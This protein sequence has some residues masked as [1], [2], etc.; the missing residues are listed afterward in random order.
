MYNRVPANRRG[1]N[2]EFLNEVDEFVRLAKEAA[3]RDTKT[4]DRDPKARN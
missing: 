2:T 3:V 4:A 1:L